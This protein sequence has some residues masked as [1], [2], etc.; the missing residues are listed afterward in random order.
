[1]SWFEIL[2]D[3]LL[4]FLYIFRGDGF[5]CKFSHLGEIRS[6]LPENV[7]VMALTAT[8]TKTT[9][10]SIVKTLN[11]QRPIVVAVP[12]LKHNIIYSVIHKS[13]ITEAFAP[14]VTEKRT[15]MG[16]VII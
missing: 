1:M 7:R 6:I 8:A 14:L 4:Q 13:L 15:D 5:R 16:R 9:R 10:G 3:H 2:S 11:M 12:P